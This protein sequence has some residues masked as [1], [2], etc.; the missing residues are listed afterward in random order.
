MK[1]TSPEPGLFSGTGLLCEEI[2]FAP[3]SKIVIY[4]HVESKQLPL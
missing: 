3:F 2:R 4:L 1:M